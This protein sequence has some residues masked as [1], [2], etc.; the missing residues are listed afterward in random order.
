MRNL[1]LILYTL[2][3]FVL[4]CPGCA[5][6]VFL[7]ISPS[8]TMNGLG[9]SGASPT[10]SDIYSVYYNPAQI[11][12]PTGISFQY[13]SME[14]QWLPGLSNDVFIKNTMKMIGY[15]GPLIETEKISYQIAISELNTFLD[16][17]EQAGMDEFQ[18]GTF[19]SYMTSDAITFS[20]GLQFKKT[21]IFLGFGITNKEIFQKLS[22]R[23]IGGESGLPYSIDKM[24]DL[25]VR[26]SIDDYRIPRFNNIGLTYSMG[27]SKS[28]IGDWVSFLDQSQLDPLPRLARLGLTW[29]GQIY[30]SDNLGISFRSVHEVDDMLVE[31]IDGERRYQEGLLGDID[32]N[33]HILKGNADENVTI[34]TGIEINVLDIYY[35]REGEY[36]D[37]PGSLIFETEG[38]SINI[39]NLITLLLSLPTNGPLDYFDLSYN[40]SKT[41]DEQGAPRANTSFSEYTLSF[42]NLDRLFHKL[43]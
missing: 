33:E 43:F 42:K 21:P 8:A 15:K 23:V 22:D 37:I 11:N 3:S 4:S 36:I 30:I 17:G 2:F 18:T 12:L 16:L 20:L 13:S 32:F 38:Y 26:F 10:T 39:T 6:A 29:G 27:Y 7:L 28:N 1:F 31:I 25:G 35:H 9:E 24:Y 34:H 14:E 19:N 40:Y 5:S 41:I